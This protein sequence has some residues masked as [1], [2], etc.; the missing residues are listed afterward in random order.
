M[1]LLE[2][3]PAVADVPEP[4]PLPILALAV[5]PVTENIFFITEEDKS[6]VGRVT[7]WSCRIRDP[8]NRFSVR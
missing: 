7:G 2:R 8:L 3:V 5:D 6:Q 4:A 1:Q